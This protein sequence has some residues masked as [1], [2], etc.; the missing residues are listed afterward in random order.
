[1]IQFPN[2][3]DVLTLAVANLKRK[4]GLLFKQLGPVILLYSIAYTLPEPWFSKNAQLL[5]VPIS[6]LLTSFLWCFIAIK[7]HR[8][9]LLSENQPLESSQMGPIAIYM[10][11]LVRA[12]W[13]F[14]AVS[15]VLAPLALFVL[16]YE[17][18]Q[19]WLAILFGVV[20]AIICLVYLI[21]LSRLS[22]VFPAIAVGRVMT[23]GEA[24]QNTKN[25]KAVMF[26]VTVLVP[27]SLWGI[28]HTGAVMLFENA[29]IV[30]FLDVLLTVLFTVF[31]IAV[32]SAAYQLCEQQ[33]R[34]SSV[35]RSYLVQKYFAN[36]VE[37]VS[38]K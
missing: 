4:K 29:I 8:V 16:V 24:W 9:L 26:M 20:C 17:S 6:L 13:F 5:F 38:L 12:F 27:L 10:R 3:R 2:C 34:D 28:V 11:F 7:T 23:L 19:L 22:L 1:M 21:G 32:L 31:E 36:A 15:F 18:Q 35:N 25:Y 14:I 37:C 30:S 33:P